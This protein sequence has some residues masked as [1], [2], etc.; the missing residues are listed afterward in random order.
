MLHLKLLPGERVYVLG[1]VVIEYFLQGGDV[2]KPAWKIAP[3]HAEVPLICSDLTDVPYA[4]TLPVPPQ[5]PVPLSQ[6]VEVSCL[7]IDRHGQVRV[8]FNAPTSIRILKEQMLI[9]EARALSAVPII[10][11]DAAS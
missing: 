3:Y 6:E 5:L 4:R 2:Q 8:G 9:G 7:G 1:H 10:L 11:G